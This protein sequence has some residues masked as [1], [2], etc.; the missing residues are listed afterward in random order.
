MTHFPAMVAVPTESNAK[1]RLFVQAHEITIDE[2]NI[3]FDAGGCTQMLRAP[4]Y[5]AN[6]TRYPATGLNWVDA[7]EYLN[8]INQETR[9]SFRLPTRNEWHALAQSVMPKDSDP[10]FTD[11]AL[12]WAS[13]YLMDAGPSRRLEPSGTF[14][15]TEGGIADLDGNVWEWTQ[16]CYS[17]SAGNIS[18]GDCPAFFVAGEHEAVVPFLVRDPARGGCAVGAPPAHLGLRLVTDKA[19][20]SS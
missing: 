14:S 4:S 1:G 6:G 2:W 5:A 12:S 17:G 13:T 11:P 3:C 16:D 9:H 18:Q 15:T 8:W 10:I 7:N 20:P 19:F